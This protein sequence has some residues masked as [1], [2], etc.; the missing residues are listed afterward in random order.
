MVIGAILVVERTV[1]WYSWTIATKAEH[2]TPGLS[3]LATQAAGS[4][5][6]DP[7]LRKAIIVASVK[8]EHPEWVK[9]HFPDWEVNVFVVDDPDAEHTVYRNR[10]HEASIYLTYILNNYGSLPDYAVFSHAE[11]YQW[12]NDD[13]MYDG[14]NAIKNL[15]LN[16]VD[17]DG[18]V[19]LRCAHRP[20][21]GSDAINPQ[22]D[23]GDGPL[24]VDY[25]YA[26]FWQEFFPEREV[27]EVVS[28]PCCAQF[29]VSKAA[30]LSRHSTAYEQYRDRLWNSPVNDATSGRIFEYMWHII[31]GK[32]AVYCPPAPQC[33]CQNFGLCDLKCPEAPMKCEGRYQYNGLIP[34]IGL[35]EGWPEKGQGDDGF[36]REGWWKE[37]YPQSEYDGFTLRPNATTQPL[38]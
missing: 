20:G 10:G 26:S 16:A 33:Y 13:P 11:R 34:M 32:P 37:V 8:A 15:Q 23:P 28:A 9:E 1:A 38:P 6:Q 25:R 22:P 35:P 21:C 29:A 14:V 5:S 36:P 19:S 31:F 30:I 4:P 7:S 12:H 27:P 24:G 3:S 18:Y 2:S 17:K